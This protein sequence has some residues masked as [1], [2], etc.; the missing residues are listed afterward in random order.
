MPDR[1]FNDAHGIGDHALR[2]GQLMV[3]AC[4]VECCGG[5]ACG[6]CAVLVVVEEFKRGGQCICGE[7]ERVAVTHDELLGRRVGGA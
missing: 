3:L 4:K 5:F 2:D 6:L 1:D 7:L